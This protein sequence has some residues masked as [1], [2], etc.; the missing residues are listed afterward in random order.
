METTQMR[1]EATDVEFAGVRTPVTRLVLA[2]VLRLS[3]EL[4]T[5]IVENGRLHVGP[6]WRLGKLVGRLTGA[7]HLY[8][9]LGAHVYLFWLVLSWK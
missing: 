8:D 4:E 1:T 6:D 2:Q 3:E 7:R 9:K 5:F